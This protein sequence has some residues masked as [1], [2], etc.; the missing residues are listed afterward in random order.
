MRM[1]LKNGNVID[2]IKDSIM[3]KA[4]IIIRDEEIENIGKNITNESEYFDRIIDCAGK[5]IMPGLID[6]HVHL[7]CDGSDNPE[8]TVLSSDNEFVSLLA[9]KN[10]LDTLKLGITTVRDVASPDKTIIN[11]RNAINQNLLKG[12][13]ILSSGPAICMTGGHVSYMGV[14]ADGADEV[15]KASRKILKNDADLLK[16]MVTGGIATQGEEPGSLQLNL[17]ELTAATEE[18]HKKNKKIAAHA[19]GLEGIMNCIKVGIDTIEHAIY[20]DKESLHMM[21][22]QNIFLVPTMIVMRRLASSKEVPAWIAEKAK[23][24]IEPHQEMLRNAIEIGVKIATGTDCG[25]PVTPPEYYF[26]ELIIM[27]EAGMEPMDVI[28]ASTKIA[29]ECLGLER[30]G[31]LANDFK[32]DLIILNENPLN[33]LTVLKDMKKVMKDGEVID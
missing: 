23:N 1:L 14:E 27:E 16:V 18:A 21:K 19:Q 5:Y 24:V 26:D 20:A 30:R 28:K 7:V 6:C 17:E 10:A 32:A 11:L 2:G 33:D 4:D 15:R 9:Y 13:L 12:P 22:E 29:A 3:P 25:S 8:S 31:V